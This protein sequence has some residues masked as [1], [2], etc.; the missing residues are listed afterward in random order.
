LKRRW[1]EGL[2]FVGIGICQPSATMPTY[3]YG[4]LNVWQ[5]SSA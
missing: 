5:F 4:T 2:P 1:A 3:R